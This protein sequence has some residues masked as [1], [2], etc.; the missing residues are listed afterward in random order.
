MSKPNPRRGR[1]IFVSGDKKA[2][3][4]EPAR[5]ANEPPRPWPSLID[6]FRASG[7]RGI[8]YCPDKGILRG[9]A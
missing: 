4:Y 7:R 5:W 1:V 6:E 2:D 3:W 8:E 9:C